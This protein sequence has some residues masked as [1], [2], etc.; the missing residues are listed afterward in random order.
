MGE[1]AYFVI[2]NSDGDTTVR[3]LT[4]DELMADLAERLEDD[5]DYDPAEDYLDGYDKECPHDTGY[6]PENKALIIKGSVVFPKPEQVVRTTEFS[7]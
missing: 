2:H 7:I 1:D 6:W 4:R 5:P 3:M